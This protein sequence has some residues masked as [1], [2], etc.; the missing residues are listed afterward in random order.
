M[1]YKGRRK[2]SLEYVAVKRVEKNRKKKVLNEVDMMADLVHP[3]V[4]R[5][6]SW[7]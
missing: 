1:V 5:L 4:V 6:H 2:K 3:N 7:V